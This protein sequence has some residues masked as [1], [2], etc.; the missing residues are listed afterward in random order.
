MTTLGKSQE[1]DEEEL[2][3]PEAMA[4]DKRKYGIIEY[5]YFV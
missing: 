4:N 5:M 1:G 2:A 3:V